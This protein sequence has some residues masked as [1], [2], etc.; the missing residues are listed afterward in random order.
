MMGNIHIILY[1][2][3]YKFS[4]F[5]LFRYFIKYYST[6]IC[7]NN[8]NTIIS[9]KNKRNDFNINRFE[10]SNIYTFVNVRETKVVF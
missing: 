10:F 7:E 5:F 2:F 8:A 1:Y 3:N 6:K 4:T 9:N